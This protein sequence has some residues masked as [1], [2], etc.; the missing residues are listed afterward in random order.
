[1]MKTAG[2]RRASVSLS[3]RHLHPVL[4]LLPS[5]LYVLPRDFCTP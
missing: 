5:H 3:L 4:T 1:L 2:V